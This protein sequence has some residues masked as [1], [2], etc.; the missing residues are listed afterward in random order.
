MIGCE[1]WNDLQVTFVRIKILFDNA[2]YFVC[3]M[4]QCLFLHPHILEWPL[5]SRSL[6]NKVCNFPKNAAILCVFCVFFVKL[7]NIFTSNFSIVYVVQ[8]CV[9]DLDPISNYPLSPVSTTRLV[10]TCA[11]QHGPC[12]R[13]METGHPSTR[14]VETG[15]YWHRELCKQCILHQSKL[16]N[17]KP[18]I[19]AVST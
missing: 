5:V 14:V 17:L 8:F 6:C 15:L 13:V 18:K 10:E 12:W 9:V 1:W 4:P 2:V 19:S 16:I 3:K 7:Q 11:R